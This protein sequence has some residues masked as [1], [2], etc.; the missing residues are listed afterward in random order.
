MP[1]SPQP[2][3]HVVDRLSSVPFANH[4]VAVKNFER[5]SLKIPASLANAL[6]SLL[7]ESP[8]PDSALLLLDRFFS[9]SN[10]EIVHLLQNHPFLAHYA[11]AV[12]GT[13]WYLGET[14]IKNPDLLQSFLR[15]KKLDRSCSREEFS[16]SLARFQSR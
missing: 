10:S 3:T 4:E 2:A 7:A 13:S 11:I 6:V 9:E 15:D 5:V 12:F 8:D 1:S 14:L 16:E